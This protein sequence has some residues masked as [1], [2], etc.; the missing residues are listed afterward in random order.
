VRV[1]DCH[2]AGSPA[3]VR[4]QELLDVIN[5]RMVT[6]LSSGERPEEEAFCTLETRRARESFDDN[7]HSLA[8]SVRRHGAA[9]GTSRNIRNAT[10][11]GRYP[12]FGRLRA[13]RKAAR[14][15]RVP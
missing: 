3:L 1:T 9:S 6:M 12:L 10:I 14:M 7:A 8:A 13:T 4:R 11:C 2:V 15:C 5:R